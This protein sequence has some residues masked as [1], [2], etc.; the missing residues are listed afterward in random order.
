FRSNQL[1]R[2]QQRM[3]IMYEDK[4]DERITGEFYDEKVK[5]FGEE[6]EALLISLKKL[7]EDN[8]EYYRVGFAIHELALR[9]KDIYLSQKATIEERRL[10]LAYAFSNISVLQGEIRPEYTKAFSFLLEW[11]PKVNEVLEL[12]KKLTNKRQKELFSSS[13]PI[14]LVNLGAN[15]SD[16]SFDVQIPFVYLV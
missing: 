4:L 1:E 6:K 16:Q 10:L 9:A 12:D 11:M 3:R 8:T 15:P 5:L 7:E 14:V 2:I 13:H